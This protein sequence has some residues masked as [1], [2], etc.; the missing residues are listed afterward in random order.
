MSSVFGADARPVALAD[1]FATSRG[2]FVPMFA[3]RPVG[4]FVPRADFAHPSSEFSR[5]TIHVETIET[6]EA[7]LAAAL[8]EAEAQGHAA[9]LEAGRAEVRAEA[10]RAREECRSLLRSLDETRAIDKA[11]LGPKLRRAVLDLVERI[12]GAHV[13]VEPAFVNG[14]VTRALET[15]KETTETARLFLHPEDFAV[16]EDENVNEYKNLT[17]AVDPEL[18]RGSVRLEAG[19]GEVED[20][21]RPRLAKLEQALRAAGIAA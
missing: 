3:S 1:M 12:V 4:D 2:D 16:I 10:E 7:E 19:G 18:Q 13:A 21:V 17:L 6:T 14:C 11:A 5:G 9:G 20:G 8:A 15:L